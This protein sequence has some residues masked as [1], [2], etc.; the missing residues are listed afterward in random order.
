MDK[1]RNF[2]CHTNQYRCNSDNFVSLHAHVDNF[3]RLI[4]NRHHFDAAVVDRE[5]EEHLISADLKNI[6]EKIGHWETS[7]KTS[8]TLVKTH[9]GCQSPLA[10]KLVEKHQRRIEDTGETIRA[11]KVQESLAE[12]KLKRNEK[13]IS[14]IIGTCD[15]L[16]HACFLGNDLHRSLRSS[17]SELFGEQMVFRLIPEHLMKFVACNEPGQSMCDDMLR[18]YGIY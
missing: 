16:E 8:E 2:Q 9:L 18:G 1:S 4:I 7:G 3:R 5:L 12:A 13:H 10:L 6:R 17:I 15:T 11:L 14:T